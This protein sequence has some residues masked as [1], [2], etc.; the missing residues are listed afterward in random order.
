MRYPNIVFEDPKPDINTIWLVYKLTGCNGH[1]IVNCT[2]RVR[3]LKG[4][5][6]PGYNNMDVIIVNVSRPIF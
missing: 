2:L 1:L 3:V 6:D 5:I 4:L